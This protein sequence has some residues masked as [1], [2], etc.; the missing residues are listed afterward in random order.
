M[1]LA[2]LTLWFRLQ[3]VIVSVPPFQM[4]PPW[5]LIAPALAVLRAKP[6]PSMRFRLLKATFVWAP[7]TSKIRVKKPPLIVTAAFGAL[8]PWIVRLLLIT[9]SELVSMIV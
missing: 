3:P 8:G 1:L 2:L 7:S 9:S 4:A 5:P 6:V